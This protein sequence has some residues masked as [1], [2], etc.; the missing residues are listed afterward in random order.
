MF[1]FCLLLLYIFIRLSVFFILINNNIIIVFFLLLPLLLLLFTS[2]SVTIL[3]ENFN[4]QL[5]Y[6]MCRRLVTTLLQ[7]ATATPRCRGKH[8]TQR[9]TL[10]HFKLTTTGFP[11]ILRG[12]LI[13]KNT[14][15]FLFV[16]TLCIVFFLGF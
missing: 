7:C 11:R 16:V 1:F 2:V 6:W 5:F 12:M 14:F 4:L 10:K 13:Y 15:L 3:G 9:Q 8:F